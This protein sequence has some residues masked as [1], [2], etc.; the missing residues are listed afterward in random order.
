M[1]ALKS[2]PLES[3][4]RFINRSNRFVDAYRRGLNGQQAAWASRKYR[5]HRTLP[6]HILCEVE[7]E[8]LKRSSKSS[9]HG[10]N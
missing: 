3:I 2:V 4:R 7:A 8:F 9:S 6:P 10:C 5:S 1:A